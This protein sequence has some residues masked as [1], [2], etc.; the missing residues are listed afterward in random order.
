MEDVINTPDYLLIVL[1]LAEGGE[2][3]DKTIE[4]TKLNEV[5]VKLHFYQS[6]SCLRAQITSAYYK[7]YPQ[8]F[9]TISGPAKD[10]QASQG[11]PGGEDLR[12]GDHEASL[13]ARLPGHQAGQC[14][15]GHPAQGQ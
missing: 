13:A 4:R 7:F 15:D 9:D 14:S 11:Q 6:S 3:F 10:H 1:E 12:R 5:E 2:L 8:L